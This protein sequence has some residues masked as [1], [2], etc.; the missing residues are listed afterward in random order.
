MAKWLTYT[1]HAF[2]IN[3]HQTDAFFLSS[4]LFCKSN[5]LTPNPSK[6]FNRYFLYLAARNDD[7][8]KLGVFR[9][10]TNVIV[11]GII[12]RELR[13]VLDQFDDDLADLGHGLL[14]EKDKILSN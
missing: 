6:N 3:K 7:I 14:A 12:P 9:V 2:S 13:F 10:Q 5:Y 4:P 11:L 1:K 8:L